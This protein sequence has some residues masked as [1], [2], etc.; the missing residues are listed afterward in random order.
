[1]RGLLR[2]VAVIVAA[3][4]LAA[5][6]HHAAH[7][8]PETPRRDRAGLKVQVKT[9]VRLLAVDGHDLRDPD[10]VPLAAGEHTLRVG[11]RTKADEPEELRFTAEPGHFYELSAASPDVSGGRW[12]PVLVDDSTQTQIHPPR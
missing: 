9:G 2:V 6:T 5:C 11:Y 1:M 4:T 7:G 8:A 12:T 10:A 3:C